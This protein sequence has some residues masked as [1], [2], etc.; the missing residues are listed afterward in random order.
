[1][2]S[3]IFL[4][5]C[6]IFKLIVNEYNKPIISDVDKIINNLTKKKTVK[7]IS[8]GVE[9]NTTFIE[10]YFEILDMDKGKLFNIEMILTQ[11]KKQQTYYQE[12]VA[13]G[14]KTRCK[15]IDIL[16]AETYTLDN[17]NYLVYLN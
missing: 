4:I 3:L 10:Y 8:N 5:V 6:L 17:Y 7:Y 16:L 11:V 12:D 14:Y 13:V 2:A 15:D 1:M 9:L